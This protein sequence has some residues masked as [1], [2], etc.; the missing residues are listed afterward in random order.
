MFGKL[1]RIL[2]IIIWS[3]KEVPIRRIEVLRPTEARVKTALGLMQ[4]LHCFTVVVALF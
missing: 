3:G 4:Q 2:I 1:F